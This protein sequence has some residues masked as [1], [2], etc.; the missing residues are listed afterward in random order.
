MK[1]KFLTIVSAILLAS[2]PLSAFAQVD[3]LFNANN[4]IDD[5]VF[6]DTQTFGGA[7]GVQKFLE[8]KGSVLAN[9]APDFLIKLKEPAATLLK[10]GLEDPQPNLPRLR[11]AAELIWDASRQSGINPQVLLVTLQKEQGLITNHKDSSPEKLQRALDFSFGFNC[12][13]STGCS[14]NSLF[15]GFY[16]QLFG[17]FDT[18]GNRY[19]GAARSLMKS[20]TTPGGRGP[21]INGKIAKVGDIVEIGN[22]TDP[23][24]VPATQMVQIGNSATAALYRFTPHV[25]NGNYNFWKYTQE[26]FKYPNGTIIRLGTDPVAFIIQNGNRLLLPTFVAQAR[27]LDMSKALTVSPNELDGYPVGTVYGPADNTIVQVA[28]DPQKYVFL[29][30]VKHPAS[31]FVIT[32]RKLDTLKTL[33]VSAADAQLF[34]QG[35][36]LTP[37]EGTVIR[38][39]MNPEVYVVEGGQLKLFSAFTFNQRKVAKQVQLVADSEVASYPKQGFAAP[40]DST[41]VKTPSNN[42][43]YVMKSGLKQPISGTVFKTRK[44]SFKDVVTLTDNELSSFSLGGF[45]EPGD[46]TYFKVGETGQLYIFKEGAKHPIST[47]VAKQRGITPDYTFGK[48]ESDSWSDGIA[49]APRD[50]TLVKGDKDAT[51]YLVVKGQLR[52]LTANAFRVRKLSVKKIS[53]LSQTEVDTYAKGE[54]LTK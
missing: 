13:D 24:G 51:V 46:R 45:A 47:F 23:H 27:S 14:Q 20:F 30:N 19:L 17:N 7:E 36:T 38:G 34:Q 3:P 54:V 6:S 40:L 48:A 8:S 1:Q 32:Q 25:F 29:D 22:T 52:P 15:P 21:L 5:K 16:F 43:V 53:V 4:L 2:V 35:S 49:V 18:E 12:P 44:F 10:Q 42:T 37:S 41:L 9:T 39:Q 11:T 26:W 31:D 33:S 28:G 50:N